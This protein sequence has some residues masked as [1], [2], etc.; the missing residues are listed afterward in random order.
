MGLLFVFLFISLLISLLAYLAGTDSVNK[1]RDDLLKARQ[2]GGNTGYAE[3]RF[4]T[5]S[6]SRI[7]DTLFAFLLPATIF[8]AI[9]LVIIWLSWGTYT[10]LRAQYDATVNQYKSAVTMYEDRADLDIEKAAFTD[11]KY[12][13]YQENIAGFVKDLRR[14]VVMYNKSFVKKRIYDRNW[15]F[16]WLIIGPDDDMKIINMLE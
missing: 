2:T 5:A 3:A 4:E 10:D 12:K 9:C 6:E 15:F 13:G 8:F 11:F 7:S 14:E 1:R 16:G